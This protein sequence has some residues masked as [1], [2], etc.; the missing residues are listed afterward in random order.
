MMRWPTSL[1]RISRFGLVGC[2]GFGVDASVLWLALNH[3][4]LG[5]YT[6]RLLSF[7]CGATAT[8]ALNRRF[9]YRDRVDA[10]RL[11]SARRLHEEWLHYLGASALGASANYLCYAALVGT[12]AFLARHPTLAVAAGSGAGVLFNYNAY[13]RLVFRAPVPV[14]GPRLPSDRS[15]P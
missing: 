5:L 11:H 10:R 1:E 3:L 6:G 13:S 4:G 9:T 8:W 15:N 7:A 2:V 14:A 12:W